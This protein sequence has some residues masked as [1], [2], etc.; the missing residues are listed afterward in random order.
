[1]YAAHCYVSV[2][3]DGHFDDRGTMLYIWH[4]KR[5]VTNQFCI[6]FISLT[7][8]QFTTMMMQATLHF[9][10]D[11][12]PYTVADFTHRNLRVDNNHDDDNIIMWYV[13]ISIARLN[14]S[15]RFLMLSLL[16]FQIIATTTTAS[17]IGI[18]LIYSLQQQKKR[19]CECKKWWVLLYYVYRITLC[20]DTPLSRLIILVTIV[21]VVTLE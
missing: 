2:R 4:S 6:I 18:E 11:E 14:T 20:S 9:W 17:T 8:S 7:A 15:V 5:V 13:P 19:R 1:M 10:N 12:H 21:V 16:Q 3:M